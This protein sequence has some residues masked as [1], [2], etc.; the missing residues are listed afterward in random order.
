MSVA[1]TDAC[2]GWVNKHFEDVLLMSPK[3][4]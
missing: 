4:R 3:G 1:L 2:F